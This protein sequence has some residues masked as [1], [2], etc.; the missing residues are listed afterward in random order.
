MPAITGLRNYERTR[1]KLVS[2]RGLIGAGCAALAVW[3]FFDHSI[4]VSWM[5]FL[6][7]LAAGAGLTNRHRASRKLVGVSAAFLLASFVAVTE[8]ANFTSMLLAVLAVGSFAMVLATGRGVDA[9]GH[10]RAVLRLDFVGIYWLIR[11]TGVLVKL[12][13]KTN[14]FGMNAAA[15]LALI[16]PLFFAAIFVALFASANPL[17]DIWLHKIDL[18]FVW[19]QFDVPRF[20]VWLFVLVLIWPVLRVPTRRIKPQE[21]PLGAVNAHAGEGLAAVL[22]TTIIM[23]SLILFN[24]VFALQS[25]LDAAFLWFGVALPEGMSYATYAHRG[26]YPLMVTALLAA[27]FVL[28]AVREGGPSDKSKFIRPLVLF[29]VGQNILLVI[30]SILRLQLYVSAFSLTYMRVAALIWM[31]LVAVGLVLIIVRI[32]RRKS[33]LWLVQANVLMLA[34]VIYACCLINFPALVANYNVQNCHEMGGNG[35]NL[36]V[37]Y[38]E[39]LG[40]QAIPALDLFAKAPSHVPTINWLRNEL[41]GDFHRQNKDWQ[42]WSFRAWRLGNYLDNADTIPTS[43]LSPKTGG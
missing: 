9:R 4:G 28:V 33:T 43:V 37:G 41:I 25:S 6:A 30:S 38:M 29:W 23:R 10:W 11:D 7:A 19:R 26:A 34:A 16:L 5:V 42:S 15:V 14:R 18:S 21:G 2:Q 3:L 13:R 17:I 27:A 12:L 20:I 40:P 31:G 36:D 35:P 24:L 32:I 8:D 39:S 22:G 1:L